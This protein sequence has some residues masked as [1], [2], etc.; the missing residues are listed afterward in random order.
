[1]TDDFISEDDLRTF[2][3]F[4]KYQGIDAKALSDDEREAWQ[5]IFEDGAARVAATPKVGLMKLRPVAG[6]QKYA[7]AIRDG[8][9]L[10]LTFWIRCSPKGDIYLF[11]PRSDRTVDAHASY[12]RSGDFHQKSY[13]RE[14]APTKRQRPDQ[15]FK[16]AEHLGAYTGH[17]GRKIGAVCDPAAFTDV[18]IVETGI[19]GPRHGAVVVDLVEPGTQP[20]VDVVGEIVSRHVFDRPGRPSVVI[21][22]TR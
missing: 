17:G 11:Y 8:S 2:E 16:G 7:V 4:L 5:D 6:E 3:G 18:A 1:M 10:W 22:I 9:D 12:H 13:G 15:N 14:F 21:T 19:L 20:T